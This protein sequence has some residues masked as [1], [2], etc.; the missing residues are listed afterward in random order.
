MYVCVMG[1]ICGYIY[2]C[3]W[4]GVDMYVYMSVCVLID[5]MLMFLDARVGV[6]CCFCQSLSSSAL[7]VYAK[8]LNVHKGKFQKLG[9]VVN[10]DFLPQ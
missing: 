10:L 4:G 3:V 6:C 2:V 9:E 8:V 5:M 7:V 1:W